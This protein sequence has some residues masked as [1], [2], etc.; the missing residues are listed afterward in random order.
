MRLH[1]RRLSADLL[2]ER[3]IIIPGSRSELRPERANRST[4]CLLMGTVTVLRKVEE[5]AVSKSRPE[6]FCV[7]ERS[8]ASSPF[9]SCLVL[10]MIHLYVHLCAVVEKLIS[11]ATR[12]S[13]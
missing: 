12:A 2:G 8:R 6:S 4:A 11:F 5:V 7:R 13:E 3:L 10:L 1:N 9:H